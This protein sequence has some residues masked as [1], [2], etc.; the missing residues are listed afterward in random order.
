MSEDEKGTLWIESRCRPLPITDYGDTD[1]PEQM[2]LLGDDRLLQVNANACR[3]SADDGITW[4]APVPMTDGS[5]PGVPQR[6]AMVRTRNGDI[7]LTYGDSTTYRWGW[8]ETTNEPDPDVRCDVWS[9]RSPDEGRTWTDRQPIFQGFCG[10]V[11]DIIETRAGNLVTPVQHLWRAPARHVQFTCVSTD[12]G[13]SWRQS[14]IIDLGGHGHHDGVCEGTV[15]E[16]SDGRLLMLLRTN[17]DRFW[18]AYSD[19]GG[20]SWREIRPSPIDASSAPGYLLGLQSGRLALAW[21]RLY[22]QGEDSY[23]RVALPYAERPMSLHREELSLAFSDDDGRSW[24]EPAVIGRMRADRTTYPY[25][26]LSYP[27]LCERR[28]G[29]VWV[30]T[31]H[32]R[33]KPPGTPLAVS[34]QE[35]DFRPSR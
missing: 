25:G 16:L 18:E 9:I 29:E 20:L 28:P 4:S 32:N 27:Y 13:R 14:S 35:R 19:D 15:A 5:E 22:P 10:A 17:L 23:S 2:V 8:N 31:T 21:N 12:G 7:V 33:P 11:T 24:S 26:R 30:V 3:T 34:V 1:F 6:G